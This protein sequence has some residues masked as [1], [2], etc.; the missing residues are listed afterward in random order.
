MDDFPE[1]D[2]IRFLDQISTRW[3]RITEVSQFVL[4]YAP[5]LERYLRAIL[6]DDEAVEEVRQ[7][8][9]LR[10][11][12]HGFQP[13]QITRGRFRD[14]L[15]A[16]LRNAALSYFRKKPRPSVPLP[17]VA[18]TPAE[19]A[20][21]DL[22]W[23]TCLLERT[24]QALDEQ[25]GPGHGLVLRLEASFPGEDS[26][27]LARRAG[28]RLGRPLRAD[29]YRKQV[30]RARRCFARLLLQEIAHTL[31]NPTSDDILEELN[32][33]GLTTYV[34]PYLPT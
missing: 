8:F 26:E 14:Y 4:R 30:S 11:C 29:A 6:K 22:Q 32:D 25:H 16:S 7:D 2:P 31:E 27:Q 23:R 34:K 17:D 13:G 28:E 21:W 5:A 15:K 19:R 18:E 12:Q 24:W 9:L 3:S 33:V 1:E 20:E 10:V